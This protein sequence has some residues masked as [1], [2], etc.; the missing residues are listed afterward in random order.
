MV[1]F[2]LP[3]VFLRSVMR[4][5]RIKDRLR[6]RLVSRAFEEL[7]ADSHAGYF[8]QGHVYQDPVKRGFNIRPYQ[9]TI[10]IRIGDGKCNYVRLARAE[11]QECFLHL[12]HSLFSGITLE[13]FEIDLDDNL[14]PDLEFYQRLTEKFK[15]RELHF[16]VDS[17]TQLEKSLQL[18][19]DFHNELSQ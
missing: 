5:M 16:D 7:V 13:K 4:T 9:K 18:V 8:E 10:E 19:A 15:I 11:E 1:I 6:L 17:K 14:T 2:S 3:D 12:R